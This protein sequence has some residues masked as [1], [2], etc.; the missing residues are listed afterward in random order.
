[1]DKHGNGSLW[2]TKSF[3]KKI[4]TLK[5]DIIHIHNLHGYYIN[6]D[7]L[8]DFLK[9]RNIPVIWTLHDCWSFTGHCAYFDLIQCE[10]WKTRCF[11]CD[12]KKEYPYALFDNSN[13]NYVQKKQAFCG[14]SN[15]TLVPVSN[16]L[17]GLLHDSFLKDY[18]SRVIHNGIDLNVFKPTDNDLRKKYNLDNKCVILGVADGFGVRKGLRDFVK[19]QT[20][21]SDEYKIIL[22][23]VSD[24]D[25]KLI[26]QGI[27]A[28]RRTDSQV[29]LAKF[30][31]MAD[32]FLNP[33]Y[34][35]NYPTTNLEAIACGTPVITYQTGGSPESVSTD[36]GFVVEKGNIKEVLE[37]INEIRKSTEL[38][39]SSCIKY[40][41]KYFD[42]NICF[43]NY[44]DLYRS[45]LQ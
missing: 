5:P 36:T 11:N 10:K 13:H 8:F 42:K 22:I 31:T 16:W 35:D 26:P 30:Y 7:V 18:P 19:L 44:I 45:V 17:D 6:Y 39:K 4:D 21:L 43:E 15:M 37:R 23:G 34:E 3:I 1:M 9:R 40:A 28:I 12:N 2:A 41:E 24:T 14:I 29:E 32:V 38:Y 33:T 27:I 20:I 25:I